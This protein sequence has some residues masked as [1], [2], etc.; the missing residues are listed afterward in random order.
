MK[1]ARGS[2]KRRFRTY[3]DD[4]NETR[5]KNREEKVLAWHSQA[6][7]TRR[8]RSF[9][10]LLRSFIGQI[11]PFRT[12][13]MF[14][15]STLTVATILALIPP[16]VTK[17]AID[18]VF[19]GKPLPSGVTGLFPSAADIQ[20]TPRKLLVAL[21]VVVLI[22]SVSSTLLSITGRWKATQVVK[23]LQ[24]RLRKQVFDVAQAQR[25][26]MIKPYSMGNHVRRKPIA[27]IDRCS[28]HSQSLTQARS[29]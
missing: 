27:T 16:A 3:R 19:D 18:S 5:Q 26:T 14:A 17:F 9:M 12:S 21:V 1:N 6:R 15:L 29:T 22:V 4:L 13:L 25:K 23:R 7:S 24:A 10:V 8:T 20:E 2:S 28:F 11:R